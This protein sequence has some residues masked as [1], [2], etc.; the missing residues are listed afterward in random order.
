MDDWT[1]LL[2]YILTPL[3]SIVGAW[4]AFNVQIKRVK[5][6][7]LRDNQEGEAVIIKARQE[8]DSAI[9]KAWQ[10]IFNTVV[11][12]LRKRI[13]DLEEKLALVLVVAAGY[14]ALACS[15]FAADLN[16]VL[17]CSRVGFFEVLKAVFVIASGNQ[18]A[19]LY[20]RTNSS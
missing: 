2:G 8:S 15:P 3:V 7:N 1:P 13:D 19:F 10:E 14:F 17:A 20:T 6:Q 9:T 11:D 18:L 5:A 12:P 16:I 4:L